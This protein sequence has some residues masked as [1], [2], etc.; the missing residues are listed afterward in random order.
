MATHLSLN[1]FTLNVNG[2]VKSDRRALI[3][4]SLQAL[5][6]DVIF[7]QETHVESDEQI[8][9]IQKMWDGVSLW[10]KGSHH[11]KGVAFLFSKRLQPVIGNIY[12]DNDG[13]VFKLEC[14]L[15]DIKLTLINVYCPNDHVE[16]KIFLE[17]LTH[18]IP[19]GHYVVLGGDFNFV[20]NPALDKTGGRDRNGASSRPLLQNILIK[21]ELRDIFR[22]LNPDTRS[23]TYFSHSAQV[24]SRLDRF[25][26]S[27]K[28]R[29]QV[30]RTRHIAVPRCDHRGCGFNARILLSSRGRGYWKCNV[31][32]LKDP[33]FR[34][35]LLALID[36]FSSE[37]NNTNLTWV[38]WETFKTRVK[39]LLINHATRISVNRQ[40]NTAQ[41]LHRLNFLFEIEAQKEGVAKDEINRVTADLQVLAENIREGNIV[42]AK[43]NELE[44]TENSADFYARIENIKAE[45]KH[46]DA[47]NIDGKLCAETPII[48]NHCFKFYS[49][50]Y[51]KKEVDNSIWP[52]ITNNLTPITTEE[53]QSCEGPIT[54]GEAWAAISQMANNKSPGSDG[55]PV[56][57]Y[58]EFFPFFGPSFLKI[59]NAQ[60]AKPL[61]VSQRLGII[62]LLPK[63]DTDRSVLG[64]W[65]PVSLLNTDYKI[66][67]KTLVNRLKRLSHRFLSGCQNS[68]VPGRSIYDTLHL[69]RNVFDYCRERDFPCLAVSLDQS[70]AFD[71][72]NHDYLFYVMERMGL[73][74]SF[75]SMVRQLYTDIHSQVL[76]NGFLTMSFK[77][78]RSVRQGCGL[79]PLLFNIAIEPLIIS[80]TQSLLF[81]GIPIPGSSSEER[82]VCFADDLTLLAQNEISVAIALSL[83]EVYSRA[84]GAEI[85]VDKTTAL[86]VSGSFRQSLLPRGIEITNNAKICGIYFGHD[87]TKLNE[88]MLME[89]IEKSIVNLQQHSSTYFG[90]A[91]VANI[92]I[93]SKLWHIATVTPLSKP[94]LL[95]VETM[96][97]KFIWKK[98]EKLQRSVVYNIYTAGGLGTFH[99][100]SRI[101]AFAVKHIANYI[102]A[103]HKRWVPFTD[104][105]I[106]IHLRNLLP[107]GF[108]RAGA[109]AEKGTNAFYANAIKHLEIFTDRGG[110]LMDSN[111]MVRITYRTL[112]ATVVSP[113][114]ALTY[115]PTDRL[116]VWRKLRAPHF[117]PKARNLLWQISHNILSI[118]T[119]LYE[120]KVTKNATCAVCNAHEE[121]LQHRFFECPINTLSWET[122]LRITPVLKNFDLVRTMDLDFGLPASLQRGTEILFSEALYTLW[123][124]RNE[125]TFGRRQHDGASTRELTVRR[126]KVRLKAELRLHG[127]QHFK[128]QWPQDWWWRAHNEDVEF[129]F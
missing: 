35:D 122:L 33:Y 121:T 87:A 16:R 2:L 93:L 84:S 106:A 94:F 51:N 119:W 105:W 22:S 49:D 127:W 96:V 82:V 63:K 56:E 54:P 42:R 100:P 39:T 114:K 62:T 7:L 111:S 31:S 110:T 58:K 43:I 10:H 14:A 126:I 75:I 47:L 90:R 125:V 40:V 129:L 68:A 71:K 34:D 25:Y 81:R 104:F 74:P 4:N 85:N 83:F 5:K 112:L 123:T 72:V 109:R 50:L 26:V 37:C 18:H 89:K 116:A 118:K 101:A 91:Q 28:L 98:M 13:R 19:K 115:A 107:P 32:V 21:S 59:A 44:K 124:A 86:V 8:E 117:A 60:F 88:N 41:L 102:Y 113:P 95:K 128:S 15:A 30:T 103:R 6:Q 80:I 57:F 52:S 46:I 70:K 3:L 65:R 48:L 9:T 55:L 27:D 76:V 11:S 69:L 99:I 23:F 38:T 97:F 61:S 108:A 24:Q 1:F 79:S 73:G 92:F 29:S 45:N 78:S 17:N 20:E 36:I 12:Q 120:R 66:I 77:I 64:N 53:M 67:S